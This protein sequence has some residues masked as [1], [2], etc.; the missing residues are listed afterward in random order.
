MYIEAYLEHASIR[1]EH[2]SIEMYREI[3]EMWTKG[4]FKY[5]FKKDEFEML[6]HTDSNP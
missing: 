5:T 2:A 4:D 6:I 1:V 3:K